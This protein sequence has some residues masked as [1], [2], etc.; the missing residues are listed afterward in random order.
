MYENTSGSLSREVAMAV[1]PGNDT[2]GGRVVFSASMFIFLFISDLV[3]S[4][5]RDERSI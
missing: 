3:Y 4:L 1:T 5:G 2:V